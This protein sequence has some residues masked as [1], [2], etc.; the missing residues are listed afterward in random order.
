[1][2]FEGVELR[3]ILRHQDQA[4]VV[5]VEDRSGEVRTRAT[6]AQAL[7]ICRE[8]EYFGRG[9]PRRIWRIGPAGGAS[10]FRTDASVTA[11]GKPWNKAHHR[12]CKTWRAA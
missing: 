4:K 7:R 5:E 6:P 10:Y 2:V 8:L 9:N 11:V 12:R 1:M 3:E